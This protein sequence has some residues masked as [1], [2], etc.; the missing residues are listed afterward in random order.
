MLQCQE[1]PPAVGELGERWAET[2]GLVQLEEKETLFCSLSIFE[3][4]L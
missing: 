1:L 2:L 4:S 3:E